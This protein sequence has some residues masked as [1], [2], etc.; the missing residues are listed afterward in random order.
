MTSANAD[1][2]AQDILLGQGYLTHKAHV[3]NG[4]GCEASGVI[5]KTG[6][7]VTS[8]AAGDKVMAISSGSFTTRLCLDHRLCIKMPEDLSFAEAAT[9]PAA[10]CTAIYGLLEAGKLK[11][12]DSVLIHAATGGVGLAA[13]QIAQRVGATVRPA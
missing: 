11:R 2:D 5:L 9:M 6:S 12:E 10:T 1:A 4:L 7:A 13:M 3:G 8:L